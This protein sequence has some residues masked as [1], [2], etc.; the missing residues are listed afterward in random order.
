LQN[1][2]SILEK[3]GI[4]LE[5]EIPR[6]N[7]DKP[8]LVYGNFNNDTDMLVKKLMGDSVKAGEQLDGAETFVSGD[9]KLVYKSDGIMTYTDKTPEVHIFIKEKDIRKYLS[10]IGLNNSSYILDYQNTKQDGS[11]VFNFI[12]KYKGFLIYDNY[13]KVTVNSGGLTSLEYKC[14]Q[15]INL[16]QNKISDI[17]SA[18]QI[19][20][21]NFDG[22]IK[23]T[24]TAIDMGFMNTSSAE[25]S[26]FESSEQPPVWR[27]K[28]KDSDTPMYFRTVDGK[29]I[30]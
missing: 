19:L 16:S 26:N 5:C 29:V 22:S 20:L 14:R 12:E 30:K 10:N 28:L 2:I 25:Q 27:I 15:I 6:D 7:S 13:I 23:V 4:G 17:A 1:T 3:R 8:R 18:Y 21:A 9:K 24:I 11:T